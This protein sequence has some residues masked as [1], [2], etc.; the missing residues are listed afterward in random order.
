MTPIFCP[1]LP[2]AISLDSASD[3]QHDDPIFCPELP[4]DLFPDLFNGQ[5]GPVSGI[6]PDSPSDSHP[7]QQP[8]FIPDIPP[9]L[10]PD[11]EITDDPIFCPDL[12]DIRAPDFGSPHSVIRRP[13]QSEAPSNHPTGEDIPLQKQ[14]GSLIPANNGAE[15]LFRSPI[16][17]GNGR[18]RE[19]TPIFTVDLHDS[20]LLHLFGDQLPV[21]VS[22]PHTD[23]GKKLKLRSADRKGAV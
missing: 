6:R 11:P 2:I 14:E 20:D 21:P 9:V 12:G 1:E 8:I 13:E 16:H 4:L 7:D 22:S 3:V 18:S 15:D 5:P 17:V 10:F 23:G 19:L